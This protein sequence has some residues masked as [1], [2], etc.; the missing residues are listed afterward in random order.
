MSRG[1]PPGAPQNDL[2]GGAVTPARRD[3]TP[4]ELPMREVASP[5]DKAWFLAP[6]G[7]SSKRS[8]WVARSMVT[9]GEGDRAQ[10]FTMPR[11]LAIERGWL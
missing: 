1:K 2:F 4:V 7:T 5:T 10:F 11:W 8:G 3:E 9:R 6:V